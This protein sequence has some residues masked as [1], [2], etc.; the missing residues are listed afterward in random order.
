LTS[1]EAQ[2]RKIEKVEKM[3]AINIKNIPDEIHRE[4]KAAAAKAGISMQAWIIE[5]IREKLERAQ[6]SK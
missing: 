3:S 6:A 4:A 1:A 5:A 2:G